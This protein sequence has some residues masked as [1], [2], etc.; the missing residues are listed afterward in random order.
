MIVEVKKTGVCYTIFYFE[1]WSFLA[2]NLWFW[3]IC[4]W[5]GWMF[6]CEAEYI[7]GSLS[8]RRSDRWLRRGEAYG[9]AK[10]L[11]HHFCASLMRLEV[12]GHESSGIVSR[13]R[14]T[15]ELDRN[16]MQLTGTTVGTNVKHI[17][18]GDRVAM[19]PGA[20]CSVYWAC[21]QFLWPHQFMLYLEKC[22]LCKAGRYEVWSV[23][24]T[25]PVRLIII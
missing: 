25:A 4:Y 12:L 15:L 20:T 23:F 19:E 5:F 17:K 22:D 10:E 8:C 2:R 24:S 13:G 3:C 1:F 16:I 9:K 14:V 18:V 6:N 7:L 21:P 11:K